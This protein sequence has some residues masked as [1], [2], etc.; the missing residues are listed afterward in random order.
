MQAPKNGFFYVLD[1]K[2]GELISAKPFTD[3]QLG[4]ARRL[5]TGRP[6]ETPRRASTRPASRF[7]AATANGV[8]TWHSMSLQPVDRARLHPD[9]HAGSSS[10][11]T[12]PSSHRRP[13]VQRPAF[14]AVLRLPTRRCDSARTRDEQRARPADRVGSGR[15][16]E[17]WRRRARGPGERR[18]AVDGRRARVSGHGHGTVHRARRRRTA[19][20]LWSRE[21]QTGVIAAPISY[22]V[23][24]RAVRR[25][26]GRHGRLVGDGRRQSQLEGQRSA[27]HLAAAR[28]QASWSGRVASTRRRGRFGCLRRRR[29]QRRKKRLS[30]ASDPS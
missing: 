13:R 3:D 29:R 8:H 12:S 5:E 28:L 4:D 18:R 11:A 22:E 26:H 1:A 27:E 10:S 21:T 30:A 2:T 7:V 15:A 17:V 14:A 9:P 20:E 25:R 24:G 16:A 19:Q 23:A 6:V